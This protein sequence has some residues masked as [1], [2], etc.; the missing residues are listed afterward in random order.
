MSETFFAVARRDKRAPLGWR[1][2]KTARFV[3]MEQ[4]YVDSPEH[5]IRKATR[6]RCKTVCPSLHVVRCTRTP[7]GWQIEEACK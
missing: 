2:L 1:F 5:A 3:N 6:E 4:G 7:D